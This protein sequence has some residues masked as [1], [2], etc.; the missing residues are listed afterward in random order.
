[1][2]TSLR[3][4][5]RALCSVVAF[6]GLVTA[7]IS[8]PLTVT[9]I[10]VAGTEKIAVAAAQLDLTP[11][12][13]EQETEFRQ[14]SVLLGVCVL[15]FCCCVGSIQSNVRALI[16]SLCVC[17]SLCSSLCYSLLLQP[18]AGQQFDDPRPD[19]SIVLELSEPLV[20]AAEAESINV[21]T[22]S[23]VALCSLPPRWLLRDEEQPAT[24]IRQNKKKI[25]PFF[26]VLVY[27][28]SLT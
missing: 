19:I 28:S 10:E 24:H 16:A 2:A 18:L 22:V 23:D 14:R 25:V 7:F 8:S 17:V 5:I 6:Q 13:L 4:L 9:I 20:T 12:I 3:F 15:C 11:A 26:H 21:L 27:V 1:M